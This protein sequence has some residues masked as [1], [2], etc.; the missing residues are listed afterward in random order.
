VDVYWTFPPEGGCTDLVVRV[1][2]DGQPPTDLPT[3]EFEYE[4]PAAVV[5]ARD[6][7]WFQIR[8]SGGPLWLRA[9][10]NNVFMPLADLLRSDRLTYLTEDWSGQLHTAPAGS[11][12]RDLKVESRGAVRVLDTRTISGNLWLRI[13]TIQNQ[14]LGAD[15]PAFLKVTGWIPAHASNGKPSVWFAS[16]GC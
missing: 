7:E 3:E 13:E 4:A 8:T 12:M 14:C 2:R 6:R 5:V 15:A 16:R 11:P 9:A 1:H 10:A